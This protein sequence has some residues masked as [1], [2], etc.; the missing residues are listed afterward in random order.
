[1]SSTTS[2]PSGA[3]GWSSFITISESS[4]A[5]ASRARTRSAPRSARMERS[6]S[7]EIVKPMRSSSSANAEP[8]VVAAWPVVKNEARRGSRGPE[9]INGARSQGIAIP[10]RASARARDRGR[11][12]ASSVRTATWAPP[13]GPGAGVGAGDDRSVRGESMSAGSAIVA[14]GSLGGGGGS[15]IGGGTSPAG[16]A[17]Q[18]PPPMRR[19]SSTPHDTSSHGQK[20]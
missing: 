19:R 20:M 13:S 3:L 10:A 6:S 4:D 16:R 8:T 18:L 15:S 7:G 17:F 12:T 2:A 11:S 5:L 1:M 9:P 14:I